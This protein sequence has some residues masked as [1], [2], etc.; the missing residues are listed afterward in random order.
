MEDQHPRSL[1]PVEEAARWL[2]HVSVARPGQFAS[3]GARE[4]MFRELPH[5]LEDAMHE[6][7]RGGGPVERDEVGN[8]VEVRDRRLEALSAP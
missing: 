1:G 4:G 3:P 6:S 2:D 7:A 5:V 8:G